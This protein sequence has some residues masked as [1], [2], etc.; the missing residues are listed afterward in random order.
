MNKIKAISE[1]MLLLEVLKIKEAKV[2]K[3]LQRK[4]EGL[5]KTKMDRSN[6]THRGRV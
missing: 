5:S 4:T 3:T 1:L 2:D 6:T